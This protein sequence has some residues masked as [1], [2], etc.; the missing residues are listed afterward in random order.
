M[1]INEDYRE[2]E[3]SALL[4]LLSRETQKYTNAMRFSVTD[5]A[6]KEQEDKMKGI[7]E[8]IE[9]RKKIG[10]APSANGFESAHKMNGR[11]IE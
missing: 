7:M 1:V 9:Y 5:P 11:T 10:E 8:E 3:F 6:L 4:D 2:M